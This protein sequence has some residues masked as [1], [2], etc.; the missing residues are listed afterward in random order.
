M[1]N[2][3]SQQQYRILQ[4]HEIIQVGDEYKSR[5]Y[6]WLTCMYS[7]GSTPKEKIDNE[8]IFSFRR[9]LPIMPGYRYLEASDVI[10]E[11]DECWCSSCEAWETTVAAGDT[12]KM[13]NR[14]YRRKLEVPKPTVDPGKGYRLLADDEVIKEGDE[15][16]SYQNDWRY[17][18]SVGS[19]PK[20]Q[21]LWYRRKLE[22]PKP[23]VDP[24][25]GYRLLADDEVIKEGDECWCSFFKAWETTVAAGGTPKIYN[26]AYRRK[27]EQSIINNTKPIIINDVEVIVTNMKEGFTQDV[28]VNINKNTWSSVDGCFVSYRQ[29]NDVIDIVYD[30]R[31]IGFT[32]R[33]ILPAL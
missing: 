29:Y 13:Y 4:D 11:G 1:N 18:F 6:S 19:T 7:I 28:I 3:I 30:I 12:P 17:S 9:P 25:K 14:A 32:G 10:Q 26:R 23:T 15:Y 33:I 20:S 2:T 21:E 8:I 31:K 5:D 24:G 16:L 27:I 22:V